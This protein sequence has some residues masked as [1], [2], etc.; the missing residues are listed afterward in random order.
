MNTA[1][2][3][4]AANLGLLYT[5]LPLAERMIAAA[6]DGFR[7][8]EFQFPYE[9]DPVFVRDR[10]EALG[11]GL[12][13]INTRV[14]PGPEGH[15]GLA[16]VPGRIPEARALIDEAIS[17]AALAG[18]T[19]VHVMAGLAP[20]NDP[21]ARSSLM[22]NLAYASQK[23]GE[24]NL[25]ILIEPLNSFDVPGYFYA[26]LDDALDIVDALGLP[27]LKLQFDAY[28]VARMGDDPIAL[29]PKVA[30][31]VGHVQTAGSPAR[32][33]PQ[34]GL[35]DLSDFFSTLKQAEYQGWIGLEFRPTR[36]IAETLR[37]IQEIWHKA[38]I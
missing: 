9:L 33:E 19:A 26:R 1:M 23:A 17:F 6:R 12:L 21:S 5:G 27:N 36:S 14:N 16:A 10:L 4:F 13:G 30:G 8:V 3:G 18:G 2:Q 38:E 11:L 20:A 34:D 15:F 35:P 32:T 7:F 29:F 22:D 28:H 37:E 25:T 31:C 24:K